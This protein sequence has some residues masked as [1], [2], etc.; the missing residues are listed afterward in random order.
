M[1]QIFIDQHIF[2]FKISVK[3]IA[4]FKIVKSQQNLED[5][6]FDAVELQ[7]FGRSEDFLDIRWEVLKHKWEI[8]SF[9][10]FTDDLFKINNVWVLEL[11]KQENLP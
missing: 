10:L 5:D 4:L 3:N 11:V 7:L 1:S 8:F 9:V 2:R 6:S